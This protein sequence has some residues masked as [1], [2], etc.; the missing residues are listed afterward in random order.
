MSNKLLSQKHPRALRLGSQVDVYQKFDS[1]DGTHPWQK[2]IP[3][4]FVTYPVRELPGGEVIYFNFELAKEMGLIPES[5]KNIMTKKL[6][7]K[8][9]NVFCLQI[10]N[11]YDLADGNF[12][13]NLNP[14]KVKPHPY[15]ATRYLQLQHPDK[16]GR[17]SGDGRGIWNGIVE[18][19]GKVW[20]VSSRGT[21][22]TCLA[23]GSVEAKRPLKTGDGKFGYGCGLAELDEILAAAIAA[24]VMHLQGIGTERVLCLID[25][26]QGTG[27]GVRAA[28]NLMRPAHLFRCVKQNNGEALKKALGY[29]I[30]R[31]IQN[32]NLPL[33]TRSL[34]TQNSHHLKMKFCMDFAKFAAFLEVDYIFAW[35]DWDGDNVLMS[36]G[37][38]DYGSIRQFGICHDQYRYDDVARYSTNLVEQK[39]KARLMVQVYLQMIDFA[40]Q[41]VKKPLENYRHD[42]ILR[43]FDQFFE[44]HKRDRLLYRLGFSR[45]QRQTLLRHRAMIDA[46]MS[47]FEYFERAKVSG[48]IQKVADGINHPALFNMRK[49]IV[50]MVENMQIKKWNIRE[51]ID[52]KILFE[53]MLSQFAPAKTIQM[54]PK[55]R[56]ESTTT[57][58]SAL[59]KGFGKNA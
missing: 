51:K 8:L 17:T 30:D 18:H 50:L 59:G 37:I 55:H 28:P 1:L 16:T 23:P 41:G 39:K 10:I 9:T 20:D 56:A 31:E 33:E 14:Q 3:D 11:E 7:Q 2:M 12:V 27:I 25:L 13:R 52:E 15:M 49:A 4:G 19:N 40:V 35:L 26:G 5:H 42:K 44:T 45:G 48:P 29:F 54:R 21:G 53:S 34:N 58:L 32:K 38:I 46:F 36:A 43:Q 47:E 57:L 22:V 24:E 6:H